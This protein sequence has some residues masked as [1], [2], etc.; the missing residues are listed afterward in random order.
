MP[1]ALWTGSVSFGL[2]N[3]PVRLV[4]AVRDKQIHFHLLSPDGQCRLRR[5]LYCPET[6]KEFDFK[7]TSRGYEVAPDQYVIIQDEEL[8][9]LKPEKGRTIDPIYFDKTYHLTPGEGGAK[10]YALLVQAMHESQR[11][12]VA[13]F[14]MRDK[15]HL[16]AIRPVDRALVLHTMHYANEVT[17]PTD[18]DTDL[19]AKSD[20][21]AKELKVAQQLIDSLTTDFDAEAYQDDYQ[22]RVRELIESKAE[23][24][25]VQIEEPAEE[26]EVPPTYNLMDALKESLDAGTRKKKKKSRKKS[27]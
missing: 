22:E 10:P 15:Q 12:G 3:I 25:T 27:A 26:G 17:M 20:V 23:G 16:V 2:V 1:R 4:T 13:R 18:L 8:D 11:I 14:V 24:E 19:P 5:K 7:D 6:G 9:Q 21:N